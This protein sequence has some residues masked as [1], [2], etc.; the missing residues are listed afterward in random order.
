MVWT[1]TWLTCTNACRLGGQMLVRKEYKF[2]RAWK[3]L[4]VTSTQKAHPR[5]QKLSLWLEEDRWC[6]HSRT[7]LTQ[8]L[9][10]L[11]WIMF[12]SC[13]SLLIDEERPC[14]PT[15]SVTKGQMDI[16]QWHVTTFKIWKVTLT[17]ELKLEG[18]CRYIR[19][20][21]SCHTVPPSTWQRFRRTFSAIR[22]FQLSTPADGSSGLPVLQR[23][24]KTCTS[25]SSATQLPS[26]KL[27]RSCRQLWIADMRSIR[28]DFLTPHRFTVL[29]ML[30]KDLQQLYLIS[31][32][33][34]VIHQP[35]SSFWN[36]FRISILPCILQLDSEDNI[37]VIDITFHKSNESW[38]GHG[39]EHANTL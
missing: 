39:E 14:L 2:T 27:P 3:S 25:P 19:R 5:D 28:R 13:T 4:S 6:V 34:A 22:T 8:S 16:R 15:W 32:N 11:T 37:A 24:T 36:A 18:E 30:L 7:A 21:F 12:A 38:I 10:I 20:Q 17:A 33:L 29:Q 35:S 31:S 23:N 26:K 1:F 9:C